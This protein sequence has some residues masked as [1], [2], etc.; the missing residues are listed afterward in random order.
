MASQPFGFLVGALLL[1]F[2]SLLA[3]S[4]LPRINHTDVLLDLY[5]DLSGERWA[6]SCRWDFSREDYCEWNP[7]VI[8]CDT[9]EP[10]E[11]LTLRFSRC[12]TAGVVPPSLARLTKLQRLFFNSKYRFE[13]KTTVDPRTKLDFSLLSGFPQNNLR[14]LNLDRREYG[15]TLP[16]FFAD[17]TNLRNLIIS[18]SKLT[19]ELTLH[20]LAGLSELR[21]LNLYQNNIVASI[22]REIG[23]L[24]KLLELNMY[25][26]KFYSSVPTEIGYLEELE[27]FAASDNRLTGSLP[28][29][30][31]NL[32]RLAVLE[33]SHNS[34]SA[35]IPSQIGKLENLVV[36]AIS[37]C[38][39]QGRVPE[40]MKNLKK[41][42]TLTLSYNRLT[43]LPRR[44][45]SMLYP[46][47]PIWTVPAPHKCE[48]RSYDL[49]IYRKNYP[50][51]IYAESL[52]SNYLPNLI[53][54]DLSHNW[55]NQTADEALRGLSGLASLAYLDLSHNRLHGRNQ[56]RIF[57]SEKN[58]MIQG[59]PHLDPADSD[60]PCK[61]QRLEFS[62]GNKRRPLQA[63]SVLN[64]ANNPDIHVQDLEFVF[65]DMNLVHLNISGNSGIRGNLWS[66]AHVLELF[67]AQGTGFQ[68]A[69]RAL[70]VDYSNI[71]FASSEMT[72]FSFSWTSSPGSHRILVDSSLVAYTNCLCSLGFESNTTRCVPCQRGY[73]TPSSANANCTT[74]NCTCSLCEP[75]FYATFNARLGRISCER[76][77]P[78]FYQAE[79][80]QETC[81]RCPDGSVPNRQQT[82]CIAKSGFWKMEGQQDGNDAQFFACYASHEFDSRTTF[83][84]G[85]NRS[86]LDSRGSSYFSE[87]GCAFG[88]DSTL[89]LSCIEN[90]VKQHHSSPLSLCLECTLG[91]TILSVVYTILFVLCI[92]ITV[93]AALKESDRIETRSSKQS[94]VR[95]EGRGSLR[96]PSDLSVNAVIKLAYSHLQ[97]T[98][99]MVLLPIPFK[100]DAL[101][102]FSLSDSVGMGNLNVNCFAQSSIS[103]AYRFT[104]EAIVALVLP[105]SCLCIM[106]LGIVCWTERC[107]SG[108]NKLATRLIVAATAIGTSLHY[109]C[110]RAGMELLSCVTADAEGKPFP[111]NISFVRLDPQHVC[112]MHDNGNAL[113]LYLSLGL[114]I[115]YGLGIPTMVGLLIN[116][117]TKQKNDKGSSNLKYLYAD[118]KPGFEYW[119]LTILI[120]KCAFLAA[121]V[122]PESLDGEVQM[123]S[124]LTVLAFS[125][126]LQSYFQPY[127]LNL[128][129]AADH[130][131]IVVQIMTVYLG[132][133]LRTRK[134][135]QNIITSFV[136]FINSSY[137]L[138]LCLMLVFA[139]A[140]RPRAL[141]RVV[142]AGSR[143]EPR[144]GQ[145]LHEDPEQRQEC[146][147]NLE[148]RLERT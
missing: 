15:A 133:F 111:G 102:L 7:T 112:W 79:A 1:W 92:C 17:L 119:E 71:A 11:I 35:S 13:G 110:V 51:N 23:R 103:A 12:N 37:N 27:R 128:L 101:W 130:L 116:K 139:I 24:T 76:C 83:C 25:S 16:E 87:A 117:D 126:W 138:L 105:I 109:Y 135:S 99:T 28:R 94:P 132:S 60:L 129:N 144:V 69:P 2:K 30:I 86:S 39:L 18:R 46:D 113:Q 52:P 68:S 85:A 5:R 34:I 91:Q 47:P 48:A 136:L 127:R 59:S 64:L 143:T 80:G 70:Q 49:S 40:E 8:E 134:S 137:M 115:V 118:F 146:G 19:D 43:S 22:P 100:S 38:S 108:S 125:G 120:R 107:R 20:K 97:V 73:A 131:G 33:C 4:E 21:I 77:S 148:N 6:S 62:L 140:K 90:F 93:V 74:R 75:G 42:N 9:N 3:K 106:W 66:N 89:C 104:S 56:L 36:L 45:W 50:E 145:R 41:L 123:S 81:R 61:D 122:L 95:R 121:V 67:D 82:T 114:I 96:N 54:L 14:I 84:V 29:E 72:C 141:V 142:T 10:G 78:G 57:A 147:H 53:V 55:I 65:K 32:E 44:A 58:I 26:N 124:A 88:T 31:G 98:S 63:L